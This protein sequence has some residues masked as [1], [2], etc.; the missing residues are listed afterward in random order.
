MAYQQTSTVKGSYAKKIV[1][2]RPI[3]KKQPTVYRR[4]P[5]AP[6]DWNESLFLNRPKY[7]PQVGAPGFN[8]F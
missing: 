2:P 7:T 1:I 8:S 4:G 5:N 3:Y 6:G